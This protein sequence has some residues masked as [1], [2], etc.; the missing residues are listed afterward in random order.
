MIYPRLVF[1]DG[2]NIPRAGGFY[3]YTLAH[4]DD[5]YDG[6]IDSGWYATLPDAIEGKVNEESQSESGGD[7]PPTRAEMETKAKELGIQ[8][9]GRTGD[10]TLMAKIA[11]AL[12]A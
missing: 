1:K 7:A 6:M 8:F 4:D 9:D 2:G 10:K 11:K 3:T 12:E 5:E